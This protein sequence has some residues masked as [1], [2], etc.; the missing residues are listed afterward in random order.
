MKNYQDVD[1][2]VFKVNYFTHFFVLSTWH[3]ICQTAIS[4]LNNH[5]KNLN[6]NQYEKP[7]SSSRISQLDGNLVHKI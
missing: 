2:K 4:K 6:K 3:Q 7:I 5:L 1:E